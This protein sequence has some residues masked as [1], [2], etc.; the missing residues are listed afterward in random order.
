MPLTCFYF[1]LLFSLVNNLQD[2]VTLIRGKVEEVSLPVSQVDIIVSEWMGYCLLYESMLPSVL[3]ARDKW[4]AKG[5]AVYPGKLRTW[6][7][8]RAY[9]YLI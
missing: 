5:G 4:L 1:N 8:I 3:Y 2:K 6:S 9:V 7:K